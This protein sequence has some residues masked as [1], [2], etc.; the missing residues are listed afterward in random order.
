MLLLC[1]ILALV[2]SQTTPHENCMEKLLTALD[3]VPTN[4]PERFDRM[5]ETII[6]HLVS[7]PIVLGT[8][9]NELVDPLTVNDP[10]ALIP[11]EF[12][13]PRGNDEDAGQIYQMWQQSVQRVIA[14]LKKFRGDAHQH[15]ALDFLMK[16]E[17]LAGNFRELLTAR[18]PTGER[19]RIIDLNEGQEI[20]ITNGAF[21]PFHLGHRG[22]RETAHEVSYPKGGVAAVV[23]KFMGGKFVLVCRRIPI[24]GEAWFSR[25]RIIGYKRVYFFRYL[26]CEYIKAVIFR[27]ES[28]DF[29]VSS[30]EVCDYA[31]LKYWNY[32]LRRVN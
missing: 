2:H 4:E 22:A 24:W 10:G 7:P 15:E 16:V 27:G 17:D 11:P 32:P 30:K 18:T 23:E 20:D 28:D 12:G 9:D 5:T 14:S 31:L 1:I 3:A 29:T 26:P 19:Q 8:A 13:G 6:R 25:R 21:S